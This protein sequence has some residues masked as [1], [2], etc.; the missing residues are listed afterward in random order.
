MDAAW[1]SAGAAIASAIGS[2]TAS[3][4]Q[5]NAA[6][7]AAEDQKK[8]QEEADK[9][10]KEADDSAERQRLEAL[11]ANQ[12]ATDYGN[13][14]GADSAKYADAAQKLSAG[15]GSLKTDDEETNPFYA[16]GLL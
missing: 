16:R 9:K 5:Y 14:W 13:I 3:I 15:T 2:T 1:W 4:V 11:A 7:H 6:E 10:Q 12:G 8:A